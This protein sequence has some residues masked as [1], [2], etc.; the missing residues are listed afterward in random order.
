MHLFLLY[1]GQKQHTG[2][3][4]VAIPKDTYDIAKLIAADGICSQ[5]ANGSF[6]K[7]QGN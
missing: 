7:D 1:A 5:M 3:Q 6:Q 4:I 2:P